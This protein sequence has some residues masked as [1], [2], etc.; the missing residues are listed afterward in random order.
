[1]YPLSKQD[2]FVS[3]L[4]RLREVAPEIATAFRGLRVAT[5]AYG[6]LEPMQR[7]LIMLAGFA[8]TRN[9]GGFRVHCTR[10]AEAGAGLQ[11]VEQTVLL[12]LGTSL[13]L[14]PVVEA[15]GWAREE[16]T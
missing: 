10:A 14:F 13:G 8:A 15:L 4:D 3:N 1:M 9:E 12:L 6:S 11:D 5:D 16:L 7:E 2:T